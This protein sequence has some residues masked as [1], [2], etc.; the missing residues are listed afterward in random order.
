MD[1]EELS[2]RVEGRGIDFDLTDDYLE[3]L[4][5][6]GAQDVLIKALRALRPKPL[7]REQVL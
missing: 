4:R 2:K 1:S 7:T 3:T 6:A 5:K